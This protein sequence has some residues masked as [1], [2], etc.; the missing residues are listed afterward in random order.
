MHTHRMV[1]YLAGL[2]MV[3]TANSALAQAFPSKP[4]TITFP[5]PTG[6]PVEIAFRVIGSEVTKTLGQPLLYEAKSGAN[7]RLGALGLKQAPNDGHLLTVVPDSLVVSQPILDPNFK[8]EAEKDYAPVALVMEFP[9]IFVTGP[10]S[11]FRDIKGLIAYG[12]ANPGK[13]NFGGTNG[14]SS[15]FVAERFRQAELP[16]VFRLPTHRHYAANFFS[17]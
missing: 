6:S 16:S 3:I 2:A 17:C 5:F 9:L 13:L 4:I 15:Y 10:S 14:T 7:G 1:S 11:P 12:R 8:F